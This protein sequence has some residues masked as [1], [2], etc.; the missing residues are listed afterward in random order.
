ME[1]RK[2]FPLPPN[3]YKGSEDYEAFKRVRYGIVAVG[4]VLVASSITA[5]NR[6]PAR[7]FR[8][9][10]LL[11]AASGAFFL[12]ISAY[13]EISD[14]YEKRRPG[15]QGGWD[16]PN[17]PDD[18]PVLPPDPSGDDGSLDIEAEFLVIEAH[19]NQNVPVSV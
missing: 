18:P 8:H 12:A 4:S 11:P 9:G 7:K 15:E 16:G 3:P 13:A 17:G 6:M 14:R 2:L 1:K 10:L 5:F 19:F